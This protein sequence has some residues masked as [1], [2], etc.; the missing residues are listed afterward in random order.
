MSFDHAMIVALTVVDL[1]ALGVGLTILRRVTRIVQDAGSAVET[2]TMAG[3][4]R[5]KAEAVEQFSEAVAPALSKLGDAVAPALISL[6]Q[7]VPGMLREVLS[8]HIS[9][10]A[11]GQLEVKSADG[12]TTTLR[13][14]SDGG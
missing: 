10:S 12:S 4:D 11:E 3:I 9:I 7:A 6:G 1:C 14:V 13:V 5:A 8:E 2:A